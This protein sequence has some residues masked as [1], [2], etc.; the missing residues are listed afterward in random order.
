MPRNLPMFPL[1]LCTVAVFA[2]V[3]PMP[4][5]GAVATHKHSAHENHLSK[6]RVK[7]GIH[8]P[9]DAHHHGEDG[10]HNVEF[11]HEAIIGNTKEAQEFDTLTPEESKRR[12]LV[13]VK[14][15]DLNKDEFVDRHELK[16]WILRSFKKLSEEEA[17]D[18]FDEIDQETD[19]RIT[20]KE[21]LQDTY[22]MEDENFK[23]ETID[24]DN[25][26]EEQKMIKQDKEMFNA[27]DI[28]KDGVLSLEE[29][30]YFHNPEEHP[31]MLPI[32]LEHTMQDK[33]LNHDGKINFQEFV[34]EAASHHDKEWL[35]TE[36]ERFDKDHDIN[37]DGVLT[38][39]EVLSWIVP[40]NTA[41]ASDE[42][43][44]LFVST[45]EDHD[46]RLSYLEILKNYET[47]VGSEATDYGD[48][49]Q[50]INHLADEL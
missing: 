17:A 50:N 49:L 26:E 35:L 3:V 48:H 25:Y 27:A 43:D 33:D 5:F 39:N 40:S 30:V 1:V 47:F 41:I 7:D 28:N 14:L 21:Y 6:E 12:L 38:G 20:W 16:A 18:R 31:Q 32:L 23:K 44:H 10:E 42:V 22:S 9:R 19:E 36:K 13:L 11:D 46:D 45:D 34:G 29:F 37:G 2:A 4:A 24:F 8:A 15:M